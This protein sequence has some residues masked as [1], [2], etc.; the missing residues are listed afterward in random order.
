MGCDIHVYLEK[1]FGDK[2]IGVQE[3]R[4]FFHYPAPEEG[5]EPKK[6][7]IWVGAKSR[8]YDLFAK[9]AGVRGDGPDPKG[10]PNDASEM[11]LAF[12]KHWESDGHSHSWC[13]ISEYIE[14]LLASEREPGKVLLLDSVQK[15]D[16]YGY[17]FGMYEPEEDEH[18]RVVFWFDN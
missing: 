9:L 18:Y 13:H 17:Y 12:A 16:P 3:V 5:K 2:W 8:N 1:K 11:V 4:H 10:L 14:A 6:E 7:Y 15:K